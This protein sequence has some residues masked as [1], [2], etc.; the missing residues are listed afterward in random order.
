MSHRDSCPDDYEARRRA[1]RDASY[2]AREMGQ[3]GPFSRKPYDCDEA[4][5][6]YRRAYNSRYE[7]EQEEMALERRLQQRRQA[8]REQEEDEMRQAYEAE[9]QRRQEEDYWRQQAEQENKTMTDK[10]LLDD[11]VLC[12][13]EP[14]I[15]MQRHSVDYAGGAFGELYEVMVAAVPTE[16]NAALRRLVEAATNMASCYSTGGYEETGQAHNE[17]TNAL[18]AF[19]QSI[20]S[21]KGETK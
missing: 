2:D 12:P 11:V 15:K 3:G 17:L 10:S 5:D 6:A 4:N 7:S 19:K 21:I 16:P 18:A 20:A 8:Q 13:R 1:N 9:E 14:T